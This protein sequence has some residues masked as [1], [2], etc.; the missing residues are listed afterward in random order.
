MNRLISTCLL[1]FISVRSI[2]QMY[3]QKAIYEQQNLK[4]TAT[5]IGVN[6]LMGGIGAVLHKKKH[7][8]LHNV[9]LKGFGQGCLG[10]CF[11]LLGK[12]LTYQIYDKK[13]LEYAW[14]ARISN[15]IGNSI[16]ENAASNINF[17]EKWHLNLGVTRIDYAVHGERKFQVRLLPTSMLSLIV[18]AANSDNFD[19]KNTLRLGIPTFSKEDNILWQGD[20]QGVT[21]L[22]AIEYKENLSD[23]LFYSTIAHEV[24]HLLQYENYIWVNPAL[25]NLDTKLKQNNTLYYKTSKYIYMDFFN[26]TSFLAV[27]LR[28]Q[29]PYLCR[30]TEREAIFYST[31][32]TWPACN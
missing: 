29:K 18:V 3:P 31:K 20:V 4:F 27:N 28:P 13:N 10:G 23:D 11:I 30:F 17:W 19:V 26:A 12:K 16:T 15:S 1:I 25:S 24:V 2:G 8:K 21:A 9:F 22:S 14:A 6:G 5:N 32:I 7:Q